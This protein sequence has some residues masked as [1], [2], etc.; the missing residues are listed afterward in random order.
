M[1]VRRQ[2]TPWGTPTFSDQEEEVSSIKKEEQNQL[3]SRGKTRTI[4][5]PGSH[6]W[7]FLLCTMLLRGWVL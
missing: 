7:R 3:K 4:V 5:C 2:R 6:V 1:V